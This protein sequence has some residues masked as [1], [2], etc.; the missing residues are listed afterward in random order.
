MFSRFLIS[1]IIISQGVSAVPVI[2]ST[3]ANFIVGIP[4]YTEYVD[5]D[6]T[7]FGAISVGI[8]LTITNTAQEDKKDFNWI[9]YAH[10]AELDEVVDKPLW[11]MS[12]TAIAKKAFDGLAEF[13][14]KDEYPWITAG[15]NASGVQDGWAGIQC[16]QGQCL[17]NCDGH[18][19]PVID[20]FLNS[21]K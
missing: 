10:P 3:S 20:T 15:V 7:K 17:S 2:E 18:E 1:F 13:T 9:T 6:Q 19:R 4:L 11:N 21:Y 16:P 14:L 8:N 5:I 12:C